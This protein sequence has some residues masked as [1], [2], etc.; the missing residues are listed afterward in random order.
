MGAWFARQSIELVNRE[1]ERRGLARLAENRT[2]AEV[3]LSH[4]QAMAARGFYDHVDPQGNDVAGRV[5]AAGYLSVM[6]AE[7]IARGQTTPGEVVAGWMDSAGHRAN[8]LNGELREIGAGYA[9]T[10]DDAYR[11]YWTHVFA[12]PDPSLT[13]DRSRYPREVIAQANQARSRAGSLPL[14][15][16]VTLEAL[17]RSHLTALTRGGASAFQS[18]ARRS[19]EA[20]SQAAAARAG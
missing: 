11:H 14:T 2:L 8:I 17:A 13:R 15:H 5:A 6:T 20:V 10:P 7:N 1:R 16:S 18:R 19:L 9:F 12:T 4:S 3:A